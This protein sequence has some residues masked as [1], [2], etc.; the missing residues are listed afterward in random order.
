LFEEKNLPVTSEKKRRDL[1]ALDETIVKSNKNMYYSYSAV[2]VVERNELETIF[3]YI[4]LVIIG[5]SFNSDESLYSE[6][7]FDYK[8]FCQRSARSSVRTGQ[9]S[10]LIKLPG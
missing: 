4:P 2:N 10:S 8:V 6:E 5:I 7:L 3:R 9:N 1:I